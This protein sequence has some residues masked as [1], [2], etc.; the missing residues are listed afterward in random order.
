[1]GCISKSLEQRTGTPLHTRPSAL[2][3]ATCTS[4]H[5]CGRPY[6]GLH[7][8]LSLRAPFPS[9]FLGAWFRTTAGFIPGKNIREKQT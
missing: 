6:P 3:A 1:M 5:A 9:V 4:H 8:S 2:R 7:F